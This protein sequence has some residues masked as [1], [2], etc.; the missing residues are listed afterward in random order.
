MIMMMSFTVSCVS[1]LESPTHGQEQTISYILVCTCMYWYVGVHNFTFWYVPVY[2]CMYQTAIIRTSYILVCT[3]SKSWW[4]FTLGAL[5]LGR[6]MEVY[7][8]HVQ[9][10]TSW[11]FKCKIIHFLASSVRRMYI[12]VY[13]GIYSHVCIYTKVTTT[14]HLESGSIRLKPMLS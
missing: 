13:T 8:S 2:T 4:F 1:H 3:I 6:Y 14:F 12:Q 5:I 7:T 11:C 9:H 10:N